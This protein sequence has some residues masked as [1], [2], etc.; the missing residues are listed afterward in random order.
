M[1]L[2]ACVLSVCSL[3][4][5]GRMRPIHRQQYN[6]FP[7]T[8]AVESVVNTGWTFDR[9]LLRVKKNVNDRLVETWKQKQNNKKAKRNSRAAQPNPRGT[10][11]LAKRT[12]R[13][14]RKQ[15]NRQCM[16]KLRGSVENNY[17]VVGISVQIHTKVSYPPLFTSNLFANQQQP[18]PVGLRV[19]SCG[20]DRV[21]SSFTL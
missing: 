2:S 11:H 5:S 20:T 13:A 21:H 1:V 12:G 19:S 8:V 4:V 15:H 17:S 16:S 3:T 14:D 9:M 18:R 6:Y 7:R 10:S